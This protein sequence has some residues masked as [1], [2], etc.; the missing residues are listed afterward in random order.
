MLLDPIAVTK[1][2]IKDTIIT[3]GFHT[4]ADICTGGGRDACAEAGIE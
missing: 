3:D 4:A 2:N 1:D